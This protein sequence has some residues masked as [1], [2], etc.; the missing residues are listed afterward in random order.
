MGIGEFYRILVCVFQIEVHVLFHDALSFQ[1][2]SLVEHVLFL[3]FG[4]GRAFNGRGMGNKGIQIEFVIV[5]LLVYSQ[6]PVQ[7]HKFFEFRLHTAFSLGAKI[8]FSPHLF[9]VFS[10]LFAFFSLL[11][12]LTSLHK[13]SCF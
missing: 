13:A 3:K 9:I 12:V 4:N 6:F 10:L 1:A 8:R 11:F 2:Y 5:Y 7:G